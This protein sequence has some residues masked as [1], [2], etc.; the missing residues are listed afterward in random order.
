[1][2]LLAKPLPFILYNKPIYYSG[3]LRKV[4]CDSIEK[5]LIN[6]TVSGLRIEKDSFR[7]TKIQL[8]NLISGTAEN[9]DSLL[10]FTPG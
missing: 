8:D 3:A 4:A 5:E 10:I 2:G 7:W 1:V 9:K 6:N